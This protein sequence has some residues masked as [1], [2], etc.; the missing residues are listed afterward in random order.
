MN[1]KALV[2]VLLLGLV[3]AACGDEVEQTTTTTV[4]S[5]TQPPDDQP[6]PQTGEPILVRAEVLRATSTDVTDAELAQL[7]AGN[8]DFALDLFRAVADGN[9]ILS[10]YSAAAALTMA[11]AGARD[12]TAAEMRRTLHL[13][14]D[15]E[16]IH[17]ARNQ[18]DLAVSTEPPPAGEGEPEPFT[19][20]VANSLW[21]QHGYPFLEEFLQL[22]G[23]NYDAGM[24]LVDFVTA[25][26]QARVTINSWVEEATEGRIEDLIPEGVLDEMTRLVL[27]NAIWFKAAWADQFDPNLTTD[28]PFTLLDGEKVTVPMMNASLQLSYGSGSGY[29]AVRIPYAGDASMLVVVPDDLGDMVGRLDAPVLAQIRDSLSPHQVELGLPRFEFRS[30]LPLARVLQELG[31]VAAFTDPARDDGANFTGI[32]ETREL[33]IQDVI[34]QAFI[35]V[36]EEGTE[37]AAATAIAFG[38]TSMPPPAMLLVDRPFLFLIEHVSTGE[39]LFVGQVTDPR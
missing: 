29:Q 32:I 14:L 12:D 33:Y 4:P 28:E 9:T 38:V 26:E 11:Y 23:E 27:T 20:R 10:P 36:D 25:T 13:G 2:F 34:Q 21:G 3:A 15:D 24:N 35:A 19:I 5:P 17:A 37:A 39:I 31:M 30:E 6:P 16:R 8:T 1:K 18:L 7:V 22:L